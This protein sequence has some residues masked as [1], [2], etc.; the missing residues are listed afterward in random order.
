MAVR[1][2]KRVLV[3]VGVIVTVAV[4]EGVGRRLRS[5]ARLAANNPAQ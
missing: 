1:V 2:G 3:I 5:G 4:I